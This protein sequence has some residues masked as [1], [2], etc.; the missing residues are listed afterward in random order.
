MSN[1]RKPANVKAL[2]REKA[3]LPETT[4]D[5]CLRGDLV[6]QLNDLADE[7]TEAKRDA[8]PAAR[9]GDKSRVPELVEQMQELQAEMVEGTITMTLRAL[10][11][12]EWAALVAKHPPRSGDKN[13]QAYG[14]NH[15]AM[16]RDLIPASVIEPDLDDEDWTNL[17]RTL[18]SGE[19]DK[20]CNAAKGLNRGEVS[21]PFFDLVSRTLATSAE[22]SRQRQPS[23]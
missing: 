1:R 4:V 14:A 10:P 11:A 7:L 21:V 12:D 22:T 5:V 13:D 19:W 9:L 18:T 20:L 2:I 23:E 15:D 16:M 6:P 3:K 8:R 17:F